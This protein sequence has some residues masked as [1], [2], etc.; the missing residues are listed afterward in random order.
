MRWSARLAA[1]KLEGFG[2]RFKVISKLLCQNHDCVTFSHKVVGV[3]IYIT[4]KSYALFI[5]QEKRIFDRQK[6]SSVQG[7]FRSC[8]L[9]NEASFGENIDPPHANG[10][11][12]NLLEL[13]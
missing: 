8:S 3:S 4:R 9:D 7:T 13:G 1:A 6:I 2:H 10:H 11:E 12:P 5:V